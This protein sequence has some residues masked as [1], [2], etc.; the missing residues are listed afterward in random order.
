MNN[1]KSNSVSRNIILFQ[2]FLFLSLFSNAQN[3]VQKLYES[4]SYMKCINLCN[5]NLSK[6]IDKQNSNLYKS[7]SLIE[8][9]NNKKV[10]EMY[11]DPVSEA[12]K[13]IKR[14]EKYADSH[15]SDY[16]R[17]EN[18]YRID[19]VIRFAE[20]KADSS[21]NSGNIKYASKVLQ[22]I[23]AVYPN[24]NIYLY[25][26]A[27]LYNFNSYAV[28]KKDKNLTEKFLHKQLYEV[29]NNSTKYF[30]GNT[31]QELLSD[32]TLLY[33]DTAC[34]LETASTILVLF[35]KKFKQDSAFKSQA[36]KFQ[37]K[38]WQIKMLFEVNNKRASGYACGGL[39]IDPKPALILDNC[40][41][42]T[43][44]KYSEY[45]Q[46][47]NFFSHTGEDGSSPWE[48]AEKEGCTAD[49]ENLAENTNKKTNIIV[50]QWLDSEGHCKNI[51]GFHT[52]A[53]FGN[54]GEYWVQM[55]R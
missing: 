48:R 23:R 8:L 32:L 22:K 21:Y 40:L 35:P 50:K 28:L 42:R 44:Q 29:F 5:K 31:K 20:N 14:I 13:G 49:A 41:C 38:Y 27:K 52:K 26:F 36:L 43:A 25:K 18:R 6:S 51:M 2:L 46:R 12:L 1:Q 9:I 15:P 37:E 55:F 3:K 16:F 7:L 30:G 39:L 53:G 17:S 54:A 47:E 11:S 24:K 19:K 45:M 33:N 10:K 4:E 34:D